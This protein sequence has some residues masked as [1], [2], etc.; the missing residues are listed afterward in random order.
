MERPELKVGDIVMIKP[1]FKT[2][3]FRGCLLVVTEPKSFGCQGFIQGVGP[4][5]EEDGGQYYL[6]PN[7]DDFEVTGGVAPWVVGS[8]A[9]EEGEASE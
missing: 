4:T 1:T 5:F 6:R 9:A 7:W 2:A 3:C 8:I